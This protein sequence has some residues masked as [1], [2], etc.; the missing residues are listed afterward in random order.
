MMSLHTALI[1]QVIGFY[2]NAFITFFKN[3]THAV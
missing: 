3:N 2:I 1:C